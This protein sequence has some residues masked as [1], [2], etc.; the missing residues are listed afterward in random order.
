[1]ATRLILNELDFNLATLTAGLVIVVVL[2]VG[3]HAVALGTSFRPGLKVIMT[4]REL[5]IQNSRHFESKEAKKVEYGGGIPK[6]E[7]MTQSSNALWERER[8]WGKGSEEG[9]VR[10]A[11]GRRSVTCAAGTGTGGLGGGTSL[12]ERLPAKQK[13]HPLHSWVYFSNVLSHHQHEA[14]HEA[15]MGHSRR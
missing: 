5:V 13:Y 3:T 9:K 12:M 7:K 10:V 4:W 1:M 14:W 2:I 8:E 15:L 6:G 11:R